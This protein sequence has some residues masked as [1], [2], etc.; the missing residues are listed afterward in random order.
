[1]ISGRSIPV[2]PDAGT[3]AFATCSE[4][5]AAADPGISQS[6][7]AS[8]PIAINPD[9]PDDIIRLPRSR[10]A[11]SK[12][13]VAVR[14]I[15]YVSGEARHAQTKGW[16]RLIGAI[17]PSSD[18]FCFLAVDVTRLEKIIANCGS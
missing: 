5:P 8:S 15:D 9:L 13:D 14:L 11:S 4:S 16:V 6:P 12:P 17:L 7:T 18:S 10:P 2:S 1:M 3:Q